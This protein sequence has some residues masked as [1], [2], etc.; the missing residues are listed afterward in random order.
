MIVLWDIYNQ[1]VKINLQGHSTSITAMTIYRKN[2]IPC[3]LSSASAEGKIKLWDLKSKSAAINFKGHISQ[4][5]ALSFSPDF[6]YLASGDQNGIVKIWD[7]RMTNKSLKE[8]SNEQK[9]INCI[10]FNPYE[11]AFAYGSKDRTVRYYNVE[12]FNKIGQTSTDRLPIQK[13]EFDNQGKNFFSVTNET[14]KYWE[15]NERG[16]GLNLIDMYEASWNKLQSFKY[17][18]GKAICALSTYSDKISFFLIKYKELFKNPNLFLRENPNMGNISEVQESEDSAFFE[19]DLNLHLEMPKIQN[20]N[21]KNNEKNII[22]NNSNSLVKNNNYLSKFI[23]NS[24]MSNVSVSL[25]DI[26]CSKNENE[27]LFMKNAINMIGVSNYK[28]PVV[29]SSNKKKIINPDDIPLPKPKD[30]EIKE[31]KNNDIKNIENENNND[32]KLMLGNISN[33]SDIS[34]D[35]GKS[36]LTLNNIFG[37]NTNFLNNKDKIIETPKDNNNN[38]TNGIELETNKN[39]NDDKN[40]KNVNEIDIIKKDT[41]SENGDFKEFSE[42]DMELFFGKS[43]N[44]DLLNISEINSNVFST[45]NDDIFNFLENEKNPIP[46]NKNNREPQQVSID[47]QKSFSQQI[48]TTTTNKKTE[49]L[50]NNSFASLKSNET[51]GIDF[52]QFL[53]DNGGLES[54]NETKHIVSQSHDLPIL[55]EINSQHDKMRSTITK[56]F[57]AIKMVSKWW[58]DSDIPS[59]LNALDI[60][61]DVSVTKDFFLYGIITRDDISKIPFTLD[62]A[63]TVLPHVLNLL[64][65]KFDVYW[66]IAC[67]T[68][69]I[70]LKIFMEKIEVTKQKYRNMNFNNLNIM[71]N[72]PILEERNKK[73]NEIIDIFKKI[74]ESK[75]LKSHIKQ[76][77]NENNSIAKAFY[78]DLEFFLRPYDKNKIIIRNI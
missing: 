12:K 5:D 35:E 23:N 45:E 33:L 34:A 56:R 55:Q 38:I 48:I 11:I 16:N 44:Q 28:G 27:S 50:T 76:N 53:E 13:I 70:F 31:S 20:N 52:T 58:K 6:T 42:K 21:K 46:I 59:T 39:N 26:S 51:L 37:S 62:N 4:I 32:D 2:N 40:T 9:A 18:E 47:L 15:I 3:V 41:T 69:I 67:K 72:D 64:K 1:K 71:E 14:L 17:I 30:L 54:L 61:K 75:Y 43:N 29:S 22:N 63:V 19:N 73:C 66:K 68:G 24:S 8:I 49:D 74:Y 77:D 78:T 60:M 36:E 10:K 25:S 7:I 57:N 65:S